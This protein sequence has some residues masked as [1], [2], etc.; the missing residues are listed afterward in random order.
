MP[1]FNVYAE[2]NWP[3]SEGQYIPIFLSKEF[4]SEELAML[5]GEKHYEDLE[6]YV[7][8]CK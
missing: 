7:E 3:E 4:D 6:I 1:K 2:S 5:A 8:E